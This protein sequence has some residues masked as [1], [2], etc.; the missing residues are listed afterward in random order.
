MIYYFSKFSNDFPANQP[1]IKYFFY[2]L[3]F[4]C[5]ATKQNE[6]IINN[7]WILNKSKKKTMKM[8]IAM[9]IVFLFS[10][11]KN[12]Y[13]TFEAVWR[14]IV[15]TMIFIFL[16]IY[17]KISVFIEKLNI[18]SIFPKVKNEIIFSWVIIFLNGIHYNSM[19]FYLRI[20]QK[21]NK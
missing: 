16:N 20:F 15:F 9:K 2:C 10:L 14:T 21:Y 8:K 3:W 6:L 1:K 13:K 19:T 12:N 5:S 7:F 18:F 4:F 17:N 11:N